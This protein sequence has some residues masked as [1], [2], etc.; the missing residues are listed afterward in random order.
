MNG[1]HRDNFGILF[2]FSRRPRKKTRNK[3]ELSEGVGEGSYDPKVELSNEYR[4]QI[5]EAFDLFDVD[6]D[7]TIDFQEFGVHFSH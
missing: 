2:M 7:R 5:Q 3:M 6:K 4:Q 1:L